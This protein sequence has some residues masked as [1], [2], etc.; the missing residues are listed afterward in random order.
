MNNVDINEL[1]SQVSAI[2]ENETLVENPFSDAFASAKHNLGRAVT[3]TKA[4]LGSKK[5]KGTDKKD[6]LAKKMLDGWYHW[7]GLTEKDG[8]IDDLKQFLMAKVG[9]SQSEADELMNSVGDNILGNGRQ[10]STPNNNNQQDNSDE[11]NNND[12]DDEEEQQPQNQET[13]TDTTEA[14][15]VE[16]ETPR[17]PPRN[18]NTE[19]KKYTEDLSKLMN[20]RSHGGSNRMMNFR[21]MANNVKKIVKTVVD[22]GD[23][24]S[25]DQ[26]IEAVSMALDGL[27]FIT[28]NDRNSELDQYTVSSIRV[29]VKKL[30][31]TLNSQK[32]TQANESINEDIADVDGDDIVDRNS[33]IKFFGKA[34]GFA[35]EHNLVGKTRT[36][37]QYGVP[38]DVG[39][40]YSNNQSSP[41]NYSNQN[42][43]TGQPR[44]RGQGQNYQPYTN[45]ERDDN[46]FNRRLDNV[47]DK[48]ETLG[49]DTGEIQDIKRMASKNKFEDINR[50]ADIR[51][52]A[53]IGWSFL[54]TL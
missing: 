35:Y 5:A 10:T 42:T 29:K 54:R 36:K 49:F 27:D 1:M 15:P 45:Q 18:E 31:D 28:T 2:M 8:T 48:A 16:P 26:R 21:E 43:N 19:L 53:A 33:L 14:E 6:K 34:A 17:T 40:G 12:D 32:E 38:V 25:L 13:N 9:F 11:D 50:D 44:N 52:L 7:L 37:N 3:K 30:L 22:N 23:D 41:Q 20:L 24:I 39:G 51:N 4:G 47:W 46:R